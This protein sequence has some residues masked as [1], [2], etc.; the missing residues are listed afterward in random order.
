MNVKAWNV[1]LIEPNRFER[2]IIMDILKNAG[3]DNVKA[4]ASQEDALGILAYSNCNVIIASYEM[5]PLDGAAW[6]RAFRRNHKL[7]CRKSAIFITS[8]AF[9]RTMAEDC[10]HA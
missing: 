6:T 2:Q 5:T 8:N 10:R 7:P 1:C 9:S 4:S 3:V